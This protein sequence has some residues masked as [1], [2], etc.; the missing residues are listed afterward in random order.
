[1]FVETAPGLSLLKLAVVWSFS[2]SC[3][4]KARFI[5]K[6]EFA[7][8]FDMKALELK[9]KKANLLIFLKHI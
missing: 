4:D 5:G 7:R 8:R 6:R 1:M 2:Y 9:L 3:G